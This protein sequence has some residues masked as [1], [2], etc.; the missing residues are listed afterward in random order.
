MAGAD[1]APAITYVL[2]KSATQKRIGGAKDN[3]HGNEIN[4]SEAQN[5]I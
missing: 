3:R 5:S 2:E 4:S 1:I